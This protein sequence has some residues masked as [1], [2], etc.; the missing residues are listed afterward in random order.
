MRKSKSKSKSKGFI[1]YILLTLLAIGVIGGS[2]YLYTYSRDRDQAIS[3]ALSSSQKIIKA[4][5]TLS[6]PAAR[7]AEAKARLSQATIDLNLLIQK[8]DG[9]AAA[10]AIINNEYSDAALAVNKTDVLFNNPDSNNP[11]LKIKTQ[12][13]TVQQQIDAKRLQITQILIQWESLFGSSTPNSISQNSIQSVLLSSSVKIDPAL[14][15]KAEDEIIIV[16]TYLQQLQVI[17]AGLVPDN[18]GLTAAEIIQDKALVADAKKQVDDIVSVM[19][20]VE[21]TLQQQV[22]AGAQG[23]NSNTSNNNDTSN[24]ASN[25][26]SST[27]SQ[28]TE[29]QI[30]AQEKVVSDAQAQEALIQSEIDQAA[31]TSSGTVFIPSS[32]QDNGGQDNNGNG[33]S[34]DQSMLT[35]GPTLIEGGNSH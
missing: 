5:N 9:E 4:A 23:S 12:D 32:G 7:L 2:V 14:I 3:D 35:S 34:S 26:S 21:T 15:K 33:G 24:E 8:S 16:Q 18:S 20:S 1:S 28:V 25:N 30:I 11:Q 6:D 29:Q 27:N 31:A 10:Q 13:P 22:A 17:V 19:T